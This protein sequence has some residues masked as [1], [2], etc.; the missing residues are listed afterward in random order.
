MFLAR[1]FG[2]NNKKGAV[3]LLI[4]EMYKGYMWGIRER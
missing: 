3:I 4:F 1:F 2:L